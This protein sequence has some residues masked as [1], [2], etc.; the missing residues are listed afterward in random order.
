MKLSI[1]MMLLFSA[2]MLLAIPEK[3]VSST[4]GISK[5]I[6]SVFP[7]RNPLAIKLGV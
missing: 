5:P 3:N 4:P 6:V 7:A 1:K 2:M